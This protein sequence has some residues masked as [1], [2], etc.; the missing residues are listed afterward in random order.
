MYKVPEAR[1]L[2]EFLW[3]YRSQCHRSIDARGGVGIGIKW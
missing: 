1:N 3:S 2:I